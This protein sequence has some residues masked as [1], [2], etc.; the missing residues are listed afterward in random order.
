[1]LKNAVL[2]DMAQSYGNGRMRKLL[3][4]AEVR[5]DLEETRSRMML[6][7]ASVVVSSNGNGDERSA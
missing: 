5:K 1:M 6:P 4:I 7:A 2:L 3:Q